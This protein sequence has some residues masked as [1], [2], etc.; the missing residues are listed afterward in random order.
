[1]KALKYIVPLGVFVVLCVFLGIGLTRDPRIVPSPFIGK[2][3][4]GFTLTNM[5]Q[6]LEFKRT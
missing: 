3:A 6:T 4:P 5:G 2:P 1:M